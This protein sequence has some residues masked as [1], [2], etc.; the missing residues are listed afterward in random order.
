M[1]NNTNSGFHITWLSHS[2]PPPAAPGDHFQEYPLHHYP[3]AQQQNHQHHS[4]VV[5]VGQKQ[6][7]EVFEIILRQSLKLVPMSGAEYELSRRC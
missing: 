4:H 6:N 3:W 7:G 5:Q 2:E 1:C